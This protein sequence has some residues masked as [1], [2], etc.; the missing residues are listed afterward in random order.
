M[1][2]S[3][4]TS[5][6]S[7]KCEFSTPFAL[8]NFRILTYY[9]NENNE[10]LWAQ[11]VVYQSMIICYHQ[12]R[13]GFNFPNSWW[14]HPKSAYHKWIK[15]SAL[16]HEDTCT[17]QVLPE[18][19]MDPQNWEY[20]WC[21]N[22]LRPRQNGRHFPDDI[23]KRIFVNENA[24]ILIEI[25]LKFVPKGPISNIPALIQIMAWRRPGDKP[26]SEPMMV[27]LLMHICVTRPQ[28]VNGGTL[29][30]F[31]QD[32]RKVIVK[33]CRLFSALIDCQLDPK[34]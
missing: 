18:G 13:L 14:A 11:Q 26:L 5:P 34:E 4:S 1:L 6:H 31:V 16:L 25:S 27:S 10:R 29:Q 15:A 32:L 20:V 3:H 22:T 24:R 9:A 8:R 28:W 7:T 30:K 17:C 33:G 19:P 21:F 2:G 12:W 23:F